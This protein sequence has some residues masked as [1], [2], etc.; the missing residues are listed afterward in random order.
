MSVNVES[1]A[2]LESEERAA[3]APRTVIDSPI[4]TSRMGR[5]VVANGASL[6]VEAGEILLLG[7]DEAYPASSTFAQY[8]NV[9][10]RHGL[11]RFDGTAFHI[12][13]TESANGTFVGEVQIPP[14]TEY[15]IR[16]GQTVRLAADVLLDLYLD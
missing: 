6:A 7:R 9:S 3:T 13:D 8:P 15:E 12:T 10:R 16:S 4:Q 5:V 14:N 11:L 1:S 2:Q